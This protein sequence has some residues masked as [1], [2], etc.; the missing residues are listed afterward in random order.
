MC[1]LNSRSTVI[2]RAMMA[3]GEPALPDVR[4]V[5]IPAC[6]EHAM[7]AARLLKAAYDAGAKNEQHVDWDDVD[8]AHYWAVKAVK[9]ERRR[10]EYNHDARVN[11]G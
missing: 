5:K 2:D 1:R 4:P 6:Y 10:K 11:R 9:S 7:Q 8:T 3:R